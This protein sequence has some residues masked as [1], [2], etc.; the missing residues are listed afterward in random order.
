MSGLSPPFLRKRPSLMALSSAPRSAYSSSSQVSKDVCSSSRRSGAQ[1]QE[2]TT[3]PHWAAADQGRQDRHLHSWST[4]P[5]VPLHVRRSIHVSPQGPIADISGFSRRH[6][7]V[8]W[9]SHKG[10]VTDIVHLV[11]LVR[12]QLDI[13][14]RNLLDMRVRRRRLGGIALSGAAPAAAVGADSHVA[15]LVAGHLQ[16]RSRAPVR[17]QARMPQIIPKPQT[18]IDLLGT[19]HGKI[20]S[21]FE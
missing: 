9:Q 7:R 8:E 15:D 2:W 1:P 17:V 11:L 19:L 3:P 5:C 20:T 16:E 14:T 4:K 10:L 13:R 18:S 21:F 6:P 12:L